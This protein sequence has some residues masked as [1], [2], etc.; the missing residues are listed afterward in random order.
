[1]VK[2]IR[3]RV[4]LCYKPHRN[5]S[6]GLPWDNHK[7]VPDLFTEKWIIREAGKPFLTRELYRRKKHSY[8][9]PNAWPKDGPLHGKLKQI[10]NERGCGESWLRRLRCHRDCARKGI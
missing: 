8:V 6:T 2:D 5:R 7:P 1:M 3:V 9:A 10:C 4:T